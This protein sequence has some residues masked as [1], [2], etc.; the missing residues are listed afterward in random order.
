[1]ISRNAARLV[2]T[3]MVFNARAT[4]GAHRLGDRQPANQSV[5][6]SLRNMG[7]RRD[8][9]RAG[10]GIAARH[11]RREGGVEDALA[12]RGFVSTFPTRFR[13]RSRRYH[14]SLDAVSDT[15]ERLGGARPT[16]FE[17]FVREAHVKLMTKTA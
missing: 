1:M 5:K 13:R 7:A 11:E 16:T 10:F 3:P 12:N 15:I 4:S 14:L 2:S 17:A 6:L 8:L 9:K